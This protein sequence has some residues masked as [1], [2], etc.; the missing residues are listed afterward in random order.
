MPFKPKLIEALSSYSKK[1][2]TSDAL[3]GLMVAIIAMPIS[4]AI[5]VASGVGPERGIY[6]TVIAG[7]IVAMLGGSNV[8]IT[9]PTAAF[10]TIVYNIVANHGVDGLIIATLMAGIILILMGLLKLG[11]L[12]K[13]IPLTIITGFSAGLSISIIIGQIRPIFGLPLDNASPIEGIDKLLEILRN[14]GSA[15]IQSI[16]I[17][18]LSLAIM[19]G[20]PK[21]TK[22]IPPTIVAITVTSLI[23]LIFKINVTY[24]GNLFE[25]VAPP[26]PS[27]PEMS[28]DKVASLIPAAF[29]IAMLAAIESMLSSV[30]SDGMINDKTNA[31]TELVALGAGNILSG[32][33]GGIPATG[34]IARTTVNVKNGGRTPISAMVH[35][36]VILLATILL[37][38]LT[39]YI[40]MPTIG[41]ILLV[42][43]F[44]MADW[45]R[46]VHICKTAAN[47]EVI[48]LVVT[49]VLTII[50][51]LM[52]A[53][54]TGLILTAF[55]FLKEMADSANVRPW[56]GAGSRIIPEGSAIYEL[57]GPMFFAAT[58][59]L[60][61]IDSNESGISVIILRA[62]NMTLLDIEAIRNMEKMV[63][64]CEN[65]G[66]KIIIA[67]IKDQPLRAMQKVGLVEKIG[68]ENFCKNIDEAIEIA[69]KIIEENRQ[70]EINAINEKKKKAEMAL[71]EKRLK[72]EALIE[73]KRLKIEAIQEE[74]TRLINNVDLDLE[75]KN[76]VDESDR[77][78]NDK[79]DDEERCHITE[80]A[81]E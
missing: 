41:A 49:F 56:T 38:P 2:F 53:I 58:D 59:K 24:V 14:L 3:A 26:T 63:E 51:N 29:T 39:H 1:Q 79:D 15:S 5:A 73:E 72:I 52:T 78:D 71:E 7:F 43:A 60:L 69:E 77:G 81:D 80:S 32:I 8:N 11:S 64:Q 54:A 37:L 20:I 31:N 16:I 65:N 66:T 57:N 62:S 18:A 30:I 19:L 68:E 22:K 76:M 50:F 33:F 67:N 9:G 13:Y 12:V 17:G 47:A 35:S 46:F 42:I 23:A 70:S 6:T 25:S 28:L 61:N 10:I 48:I 4:V 74:L 75:Q 36:V 27:I 55:L 21:L 34:A 44:N 40:P 45:K